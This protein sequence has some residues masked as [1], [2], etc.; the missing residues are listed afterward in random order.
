LLAKPTGG[1]GR[2]TG[3]PGS[4]RKR[5]IFVEQRDKLR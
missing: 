5:R 1:S 4:L 2:P 3:Y